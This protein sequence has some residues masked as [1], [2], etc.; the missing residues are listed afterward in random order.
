MQIIAERHTKRLATWIAQS[1]RSV[2]INGCVEHVTKFFL[3][4]G[5]HD[6]HV[7]EDTHVG[8]I[9]NTML[10]LTIF[11][12]NTCTIQDKNHVEILHTDIMYN[13]VECTLQKSRI[14]CYYRAHPSYRQTTSKRHSML[15]SDTHVEEGVGQTLVQLF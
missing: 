11:S 7:G 1:N 3:V 4:L 6:L 10:C 12:Y 2:H 8:N 5:S 13:L 9:E 15:L 14:D